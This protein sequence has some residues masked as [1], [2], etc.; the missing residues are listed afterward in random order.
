V[1]SH[2][3]FLIL[4]E[5]LLGLPNTSSVINAAAAKVLSPRVTVIEANCNSY[6]GIHSDV[7]YALQ[8][9]T[10]T[11]TGLRFT[12]ANINSTLALGIHSANIKSLRTCGSSDGICQECYKA[13]Y[14]SNTSPNVGETVS[15]ANVYPMATDVI[16]GNGMHTFLLPSLNELDIGPSKGT[17]NYVAVFNTSGLVNPASYILELDIGITF[18]NPTTINEVYSVHYFREI[19]APFLKYISSTFSGG[20][21]G[22]DGLPTYSETLIVCQVSVNLLSS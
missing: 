20:L 18:T 5:A 15:I 22:V 1:R 6:L 10:S 9:K 4:E 2:S 19:T 12:E 13:Y 8:G 16:R 7:T 17:L 3:N 14:M 11:V 21:L